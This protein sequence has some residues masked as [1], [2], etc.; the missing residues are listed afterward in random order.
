MKFKQL[1]FATALF[2]ALI[3]LGCKKK[4]YKNPNKNAYKVLGIWIPEK[5]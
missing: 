5:I 3:M 1:L 4:D 2:P